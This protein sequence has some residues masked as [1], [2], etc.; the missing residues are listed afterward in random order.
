MKKNYSLILTLLIIIFLTVPS[1][2]AQNRSPEFVEKRLGK[3]WIQDIRFSP[4]GEQFAV[5][6]TIGIWI[7]DSNDGE[8]INQFEGVM[9][10]A[11]AISYSPGGQYLAAAHQDQTIRIW[12]PNREVQSRDTPTL[13]GHR[14]EILDLTYSPDGTKIASASADRNI[15]L[16]ELRNFESDSFESRP[17]PYRDTVLSVA[18]SFDNRLVAGGSADGIIQVWDADTGDIIYKFE[19]HRQA[20]KKVIFSP[21][22]TK[23][24]SASLDQTVMIWSLVGSEGRLDATIQHDSP[25][26]TVSYFPNGNS[27]VTGGADSLVRIWDTHTQEN[28]TTFT[29]H[30]EQ[31]SVLDC[32]PD[33]NTIVSG[34]S[35]GTVILWDLIGRRARFKITGHT[36]RIKALAYIQDNRIRACGTGLDGRLRIWDAETGS[37]LSILRDHFDLTQSVVFSNDGKKVAS[38]GNN[39]GIVFLSDVERVL[40]RQNSIQDPTVSHRFEG[41]PHGISALAISP[42]NSLL[43]TGGT[44]GRIHLFNIT[45]QRELN[46]LRGAQNTITALTFS[47]DGRVLFSGEENGTL[48]KWDAGTGIEFGSGTEIGPFGSIS[49][50]AFIPTDQMLVMGNSKGELLFANFNDRFNIIGEVSLLSYPSEITTMIFSEDGETLTVGFENGAIINCNLQK[51]LDSLE[52]PIKPLLIN[53]NTQNRDSSDE[54]LKTKLSAQEIAQKTLASTVYLQRLNTNGDLLGSGSGFFVGKN[55]IAT[56]YHV[57]DGATSLFARVVGKKEWFKVGNITLTDKENDLAILKVSGINVKQL[58]LANSDTAQIGETVYVIGNPHRLEGT[59]SKG[60]VSGIRELEKGK[61]IQIDAPIS[62]GSSGGPVL[63]SYGEVIGVA[64]SGLSSKDSQNLNFAVPSNYLK[65]LIT[66]TKGN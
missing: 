52:D 28:N 41:N 58:P 32:S 43:A 37:E 30:T 65:K 48:R 9:G 17:L 5:A 55:M 38:G 24:T 31:V 42:Q 21:D 4:N 14:R 39:N 3:G 53:N 36:G 50:I 61:W 18:F 60:I 12:E 13:T 56:N 16:W 29:D 27:F 47:T 1:I 46:T 35:D 66:T 51:L 26:N 15:R 2:F 59:F 19:E 7:Y 64:T 8:P 63:N 10:G 45:T 44:D 23:L 11:N 22:R 25:V 40:R 20:V 57:V 33:G 54:S 62:P 6:T 49:S 34:S